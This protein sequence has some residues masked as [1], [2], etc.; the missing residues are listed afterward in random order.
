MIVPSKKRA[1]SLTFLRGAIERGADAG[2]R[3]AIGRLIAAHRRSL[4]GERG[5]AFREIDELHL[6]CRVAQ[7]GIGVLPGHVELD[8]AERRD[9]IMAAQQPSAL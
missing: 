1:R 5:G 9:R 3:I 6:F 4:D 2:K 7:E 8:L